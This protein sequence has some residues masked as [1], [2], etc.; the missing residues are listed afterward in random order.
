MP[1]KSK[2]K[3]PRFTQR[4]YLW[5]VKD[6]SSIHPFRDEIKGN[7]NKRKNT[8]YMAMYRLILL[9]SHYIILVYIMTYQVLLLEWL[10]FSRFQNML[11]MK[12][13]RNN[14]LFSFLSWHSPG[15]Y[16]SVPLFLISSIQNNAKL[17]CS[18]FVWR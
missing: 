11:S 6:L 16:F 15:K 12:N 7:R 17:G 18:A 4:T 8:R 5:P 2:I 9:R 14:I 13:K 3:L 10:V 1:Q